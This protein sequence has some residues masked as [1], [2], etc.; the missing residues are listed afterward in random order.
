MKILHISP[1]YKPAHRYGGP[2]ASIALLCE[3]I[4]DSGV[5]L[6]VI[7]TTAN[8]RHEL[9]IDTSKTHCVD[10]V[11]VRYFRRYTKDHTHFA[12]GLFKYLLRQ[13]AEN[14]KNL[15][16]HIHSWWNFT[17]LLSCLIA[18][19]KNI[20][21][22]LSPRGML[23][24]YSMT[25]RH[26]MLK[27]LLHQLMGKHLIN[28]CHI[29]ATS[30]KEHQDILQINQHASVTI[31]PNLLPNTRVYPDSKSGNYTFNLLFLSRIEEK[32]GL[33]LLF[34]ALASLHFPWK[35]IIAGTG[36]SSYLKKLKDSCKKLKIDS[37]IE[38][39]GHI[40]DADK[41]HVLA[42]SDLL[43]LF[44]FNENFANAVGESLSVGTAVAISDQ[45]G[46]A[47][48]VEEN[49]LGWITDNSLEGV[50]KALSS[51]HEDKNKRDRIR[52]T[53]PA[54]I[55]EYFSK[56]HLLGRYIHLYSQLR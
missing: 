52:A 37:S 6:E 51:A 38:W 34:E 9:N 35:L 26:P 46:L 1:S 22:L 21:V 42:Q 39:A 2:I 32:K 8:G 13:I 30:E 27:Y 24:R 4:A 53:A 15:I 14:Q 7:T 43:V 41:Y 11:S 17:A 49:D 31:I 48:F 18:R 12:P 29:H 33:E 56:Q 54:L 50:I 36:T 10:G 3:A 45:V 19:Y 20:P 44:S 16:I 23:T 47:P 55:S 40:N 5:S 25:N 28:H